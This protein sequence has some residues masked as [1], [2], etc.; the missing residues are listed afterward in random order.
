MSVLAGEHA[1]Q[2]ERRIIFGDQ[3]RVDGILRDR[4]VEIAESQTSRVGPALRGEHASPTTG[5]SKFARQE[6][7]LMELLKNVAPIES[8]N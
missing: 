3:D 7:R 6:E 1:V 4:M 8:R 2:M 5:D